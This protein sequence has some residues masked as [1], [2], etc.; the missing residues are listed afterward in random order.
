MQPYRVSVSARFGDV[1][2]A[3]R[4]HMRRSVIVTRT[5]PPHLLATPFLSVS[6]RASWESHKP[7]Q[8][9][10][11]PRESR[12]RS[13]SKTLGRDCFHET[14]SNNWHDEAAIHSLGWP[15]TAWWFRL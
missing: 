4:T 6:H 10:K 5:S 7:V 12:P 2:S 13:E 9:E 1:G 8:R 14:V 15:M 3:L 11:L